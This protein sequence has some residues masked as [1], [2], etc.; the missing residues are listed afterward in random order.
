L[1]L[2]IAGPVLVRLAKVSQGDGAIDS[3]NDFGEL[4]VFGQFGQDITAAHTT[5]GT[6]K[7]GAFQGQQDLFQVGLGKPCAVG[8][9]AN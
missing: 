6:N 3:G 7:T 5:L 2:V 4:D 8:N 1:T 9:V